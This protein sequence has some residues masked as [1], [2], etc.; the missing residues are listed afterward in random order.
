MKT[1]EVMLVKGFPLASRRCERKTFF[2]LSTRS[3][4]FLKCAV[5]VPLVPHNGRSW[6]LHPVKCP[7]STAFFN[8][9]TTL[10]VPLN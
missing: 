8:L 2:I 7:V 6:L 3:V 5:L 10:L 1:A 4:K 9:N